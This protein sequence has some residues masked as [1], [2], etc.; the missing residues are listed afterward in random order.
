MKSFDL[1]SALF[2]RAMEALTAY[3]ATVSTKYPSPEA[4]RWHDRFQALYQVIQDCRLV[5]EFEAWKEG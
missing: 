4:E 2:V 5:E 1:K 3:Q